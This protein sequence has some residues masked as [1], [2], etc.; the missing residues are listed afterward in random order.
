MKFV[1]RAE[2]GI[3]RVQAREAVKR[4]IRTRGLRK[5]D[6]LPTYTEISKQM[7]FAIL[8]IQRAMDDLADE[9][10]VYRLH[11]K[12]TFVGRTCADSPVELTRAALVFPSSPS[13]L[14]ETPHLNRILS[15]ILEMCGRRKVDLNFLSLFASGGRISP[16]KIAEQAEGALL[17][18]IDDESYLASF[19][20]EGV[21]AVAVDLYAPEVPLPYVAVDNRMAVR[22]VME[23]LVSLGHRSI[24]YVEVNGK[25]AA[26][27]GPG[28][29]DAVERREAYLAFMQEAGLSSFSKVYNLNAVERTV[30]V[31]PLA[32][33]LTQENGPTA[34]MAYDE[35]LAAA[36]MTAFLARGV[37]VPQAVSLAAAAGA[38][39]VW[40]ASPISLTRG[41][42]DFRRMGG[43]AVVQLI[44]RCKSP[45]PKESRVVRI[46]S[47]LEA[48]GTT[49]RVVVGGK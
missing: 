18:N 21:P 31:A 4:L 28:A 34:I 44:E 39:V 38:D 23:H 19:V 29:H 7:G 47:K 27:S 8:T 10:V 9:G 43:E 48:G 15:G 46:G 42:F 3:P 2:D 36:I 33:A 35:N 20:A 13:F 26:V 17:L 14:V 40:T 6:R 37:Q 1:Q 45:R 16:G 49:A 22:Q 11:G 25:N 12:G 5:G 30:E 32:D 24:G 41:V